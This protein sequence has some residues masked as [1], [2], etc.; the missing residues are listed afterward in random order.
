MCNQDIL[1]KNQNAQQSIHG[2]APEHLN[3]E[4]GELAVLYKLAEVEQGRFL[5]FGYTGHEI[6]DAVYDTLLKVV[7]TLFTQKSCQKSHHHPVLLRVFHA[8]LAN[9]LHNHHLELIPDICHKGGYLLHQ[10]VHTSFI[11]SFQEGGD[12]KGRYGTVGI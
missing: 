10:S 5:C 8:Q 6:Y 11:S 3:D 4:L 12:S 7:A 1:Q 9:G 2:A